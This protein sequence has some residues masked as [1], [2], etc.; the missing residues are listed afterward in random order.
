MADPTGAGPG[1]EQPAVVEIDPMVFRKV[2]G[3]F[4]TGVTVISSHDAGRP[5]GLAVGSFFSVSLDPPLVGFCVS[6]ASST[7]PIIERAGAFGVSILADDQHE[8]SNQFAS[9]SDDKFAGLGWEGA[10]VTGSPLLHGAM[11]H[12]DC[13]LE[14]QFPGG[15]HVIVIGRVRALE[16]RRED[17]G[18]LVY[19]QGGYGR[20]EPLD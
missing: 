15:D 7:W 16:V 4:P 18:S 20:H 12:L 11:A 6:N 17:T 13:E 9:R 8:V 1:D 14:D 19:F 10:P 3:H 5:V 2:L